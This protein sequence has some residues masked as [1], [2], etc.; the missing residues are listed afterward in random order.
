MG[1]EKG[2]VGGVQVEGGQTAALN[3][4]GPSGAASQDPLIPA[5]G[6]GRIRTSR[7]VSALVSWSN[8]GARYAKALFTWS[9]VRRPQA[10]SSSHLHSMELQTVCS[11]AWRGKRP[12][13]GGSCAAPPLDL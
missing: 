13:Y 10:E 5:P 11:D 4:D 6:I 9:V 7:R 3:W 2:V 8:C 12:P 1:L